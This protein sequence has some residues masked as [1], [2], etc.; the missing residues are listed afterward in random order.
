MTGGK[1]R[2]EIETRARQELFDLPKEVV[3][4]IADA[5]ADLEN[6]PR[7]PGAKKLIAHE[8]YRIR[9]GDYRVLYSIDY[10][11]RCLRIYRIAHRREVYR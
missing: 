3:R 8:G 9:V 2:I 5:F 10:K 7:P 1:Y 4:R 6:N 11:G